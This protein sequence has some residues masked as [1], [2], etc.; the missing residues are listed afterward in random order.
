MRELPYLFF[1]S[2]TPGVRL[3]IVI[4]VGI[5]IIEVLFRIFGML[6]LL[7]TIFGLSPY[8]VIES[9]KIYQ[10]FTYTFFHPPF[11]S[12]AFHLAF[13]M[14]ILYFFGIELEEN[15]GKRIF[16][17]YYLFST[18]LTG[19]IITI[20]AFVFRYENIFIIGSDSGIY[21]IMLAYA[22][23]YPEREILFMF[24]FPI[25]IKYL[26]IGLVVISLLFA[27]TSEG[28]IQ[29]LMLFGMLSGYIFIRYYT[30]I[31]PYIRKYREK[32]ELK[33]TRK[34]IKER[35]ALRKEY[36]R[37]LRKIEEEGEKSLTRREKKILKTASMEFGKDLEDGIH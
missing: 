31:K 12:S 27:P 11:L 29:F 37:I 33:K 10:V 13:N 17:K 8:M 34:R 24:L 26:V 16:I 22:L 32:N 7:E 19:I 30:N 5:F 3:L 14:L 6:G 25:K 9:Y 2:L 35:I 4:N 36:E 21:A 20:I 15:W 1:P 23:T 28:F 18:T